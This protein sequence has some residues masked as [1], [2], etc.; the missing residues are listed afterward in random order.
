[1]DDLMTWLGFLL[2]TAGALVTLLNQIRGEREIRNQIIGGDG[3][4]VMEFIPMDPRARHAEAYISNR[5][6]NLLY[7]IDIEIESVGFPDYG[8]EENGLVHD[9]NFM[10]LE[11]PKEYRVGTVIPEKMRRTKNALWLAGKEERAN[12]SIGFYARNGYWRQHLSVYWPE[13]KEKPEV[14]W[15]IR[16]ERNRIGSPPKCGYTKGFPLRTDGKPDWR[17]GFGQHS[18]KNYKHFPDGCEIY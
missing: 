8:L 10:K 15:I 2:L 18:E 14:A 4:A 9:P 13:G 12:I 1:M 17:F 3:F 5:G 11:G 7:D 6:K 16:D